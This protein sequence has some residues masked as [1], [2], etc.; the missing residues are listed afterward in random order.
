M[1]NI[2]GTNK[3][4]RVNGTAQSDHID[5]RQGDDFLFGGAGDDFL[6]G[7]VGRD[8]LDGGEGDDYLDGGNG[9]DEL[10]GGAGN[11]TIVGGNAGDVA[12]YSGLSTDYSVE[13]GPVA[14]SYIVTDLRPGS[15]DGT[16]LVTGI[17]FAGFVDGTFR[18][19][20]LV[21]R[22]PP[23]PVNQAPVAADDAL[24]LS[25]D[26][27]PVEVSVQLLANDSDPDADAITVTA[28]QAVS[29]KGAS[30]SVSP[31]GQVTY[32][33]GALFSHLEEGQTATDSFTYTITDSAGLSST[34]TATVTITGVSPIPDAFFYVAEDAT[35]EDMLGSILEYMGIEPVA[36]ETDGLL[37]TLDFDP[38]AGGLFFTADHDSSD[39]L[40][41]DSPLQWTYF[42]VI[43]A[44]GESRL[45]GMAINGVNDQI[46]AVDDSL[47]IGEGAVS[48]NLWSALV[49][50]DIDPDSG[51]GGRRIASIDTTGTLGSLSLSNGGQSLTYSA[52]GIDLAPG[53][54]LTDTFTYTVDDT[55]GSTDT[56]T[57]TVTITGAEDG[58]VSLSMAGE[59]GGESIL[60][61][62]LAEGEAETLGEFQSLPSS[63]LD[64]AV[65]LEW[66]MI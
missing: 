53:E 52:E 21:G 36:V 41:P 25:E 29:A 12:R 57:V 6:F 10:T 18:P 45:I 32:D 28:V 39:A 16:D 22:T 63:P 11:D 61:A 49:G 38:V 33:P 40:L 47:A 1:A 24:T 17:S 35:S 65:G 51:T 9:G 43:G 55:Y 46:V 27:G 26:S 20:D 13:L 31:D 5:G 60:S 58:G 50:N 64:A 19:G 8:S 30:V 23:P 62:F 54:T 34:A 42:T 2:N 15:P 48:G 3:G 37:G 59:S 14:H 7:G 4:D 44:E 56:G 66:Q